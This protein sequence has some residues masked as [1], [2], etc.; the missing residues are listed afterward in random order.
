MTTTGH[1]TEIDIDFF[2]DFLWVNS[3]FTVNIWIAEHFLVL[4]C[5]FCEALQFILQSVNIDIHVYVYNLPL[6]VE[7]TTLALY[8]WQLWGKFLVFSVVLNLTYRLRPRPQF[9]PLILHYC[10]NLHLQNKTKQ[11]WNMCIKTNIY[12]I[13]NIF[14]KYWKSW[15]G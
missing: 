7:I 9:L 10:L 13:S 2:S 4:T 11:S 6:N 1:V 8:L 12:Y 14:D 15:N 3:R 5:K